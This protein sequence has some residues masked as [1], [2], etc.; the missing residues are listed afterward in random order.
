MRSYVRVNVSIFRPVI[1]Q[2]KGKEARVDT[3][4]WYDILVG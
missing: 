4:E 1:Y 3:T 2:G